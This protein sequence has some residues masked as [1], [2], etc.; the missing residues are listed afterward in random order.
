M[1]PYLISDMKKK[2][3]ITYDT[4]YFVKSQKCRLLYHF[5]MNQD[6][7]STAK[8]DA[9]NVVL[10]WSGQNKLCNDHSQES[11]DLCQFLEKKSCV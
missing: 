7:K 11:F 5:I 6:M 2:N 10:Q 9:F 8:K 1:S 4:K 3:M